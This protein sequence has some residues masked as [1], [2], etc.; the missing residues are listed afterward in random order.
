MAGLFDKK[1][2]LGTALGLGGTISDPSRS[3]M[4]GLLAAATPPTYV[5]T[6][7]EAGPRSYPSFELYKDDR[8]EW[9]WRYQASNT[10]IIADSG[11]GYK[12]RADAEHGIYL[13]VQVSVLSRVWMDTRLANQS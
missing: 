13:I 10:K 11:E 6:K 9:R 5:T 8:N 4:G 2:P 12:R 7:G 3:L 1:Y